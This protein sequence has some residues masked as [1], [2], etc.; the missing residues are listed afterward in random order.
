MRYLLALLLAGVLI[1]G[2]FAVEAGADPQPAADA[3]PSASGSQLLLVAIARTFS[4][5]RWPIVA[6]VVVVCLT[7]AA[8]CP[9]IA[10]KQRHSAHE[11]GRENPGDS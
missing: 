5:Y 3:S 10:R 1:G 7:T 9:K 11:P 4:Q 8:L 2:L 6:G